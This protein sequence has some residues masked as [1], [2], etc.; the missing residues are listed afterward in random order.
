MSAHRILVLQSPRKPQL[1]QALDET[2][3]SSHKEA[4]Q[5]QLLNDLRKNPKLGWHQANMFLSSQ[6]IVNIKQECPITWKI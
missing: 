1:S 2:M 6:F 4:E 3:L 5:D